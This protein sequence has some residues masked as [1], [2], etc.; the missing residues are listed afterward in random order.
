MVLSAFAHLLI[1]NSTASFV[2]LTGANTAAGVKVVRTWAFNDVDV[3]P[4]NGTWF[5]HIDNAK[6]TINTGSNGL[7]KLDVVVKEA[8]NFGIYL[9]LTLTNNWNPRPLLDD[10]DNQVNKQSGEGVTQN[11]DVTGG[12]DNLLPRNTLSNDYGGMDVYIRQFGR[13]THDDFYTNSTILDAFQNYTSYVVSRY[14][15]SPAIFGWEIANDPRCNS[16]ISSSKACNAQTITS[17]LHAVSTHIREVDPNHLITSGRGNTTKTFLDTK[18]QER[19]VPSSSGSLFDGSYGIDNEDIMSIPQISYGTFGLFP[20]QVCYYESTFSKR[21]GKPISLIGFGLVT[22]Q[23]AEFFV[24]FNT[25][26][27]PFGPDSV[28]PNGGLIPYGVTD[29]Q[30]DDAY[31]QW[32]NNG[33]TLGISSMMQY[34]WSQTNLTGIL[35]S[36]IQP[37]QNATALSQATGISPND[38]YFNKV[39]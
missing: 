26:V 32:L 19:A 7:S 33:Y 6:I 37:D 1:T 5:Q 34:Q 15:N 25:S 4:K 13:T 36:T 20:D 21:F 29:Q 8:E 31:S 23:N 35:G 39:R 38:G 2:L 28:T 17:W 10:L 18:L 30:R 27:A 3:I 12:T 14:V 22:G 24:P 11:R 16:S 9:M